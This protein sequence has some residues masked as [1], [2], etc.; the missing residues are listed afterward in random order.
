M[1]SRFL[2]NLKVID[3]IL[4]LLNNETD[5]NIVCLHTMCNKLKICIAT[6]LITLRRPLCQQVLRACS[7]RCELTQFKN[8]N[9]GLGINY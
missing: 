4:K 6:V 7:N 3:L 9:I 5:K 8:A 2:P 1:V